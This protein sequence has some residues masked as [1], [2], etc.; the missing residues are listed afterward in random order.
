MRVEAGM[1]QRDTYD[2]CFSQKG[3][4]VLEFK[5]TQFIPSLSKRY[6]MGRSRKSKLQ[7]QNIHWHME[8]SMNF[9]GIK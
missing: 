9:R 4:V 2:K 3:E 5:Y 8:K 6:F 1:I 7:Y